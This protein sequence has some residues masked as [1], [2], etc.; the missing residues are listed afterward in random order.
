MTTNRKRHL[1]SE[2]VLLQTS[3]RLL[4]F[5]KFLK[6]WRNC[7][8]FNPEESK[9]KKKRKIVLPLHKAGSLYCLCIVTNTLFSCSEQ[10]FLCSTKF[11]ASFHCLDFDKFLKNTSGL[12]LR[13]LMHIKA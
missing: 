12:Q 5:T 10:L 4:T 8:V 13:L 1:K 6:C 2:F 3:S 7:L 11:G 9:K